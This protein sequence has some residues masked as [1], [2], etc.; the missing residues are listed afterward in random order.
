MTPIHKCAKKLSLFR[1]HG[2]EKF[3]LKNGPVLGFDIDT[4]ITHAGRDSGITQRVLRRKD[5][6][7]KCFDPLTIQI[8]EDII[9]LCSPRRRCV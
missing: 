3:L 1:N 8:M 6:I 4:D 7:V 5:L 9:S 2:L